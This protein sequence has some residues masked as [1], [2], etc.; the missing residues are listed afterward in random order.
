M[1]GLWA[2]ILLALLVWGYIYYRNN[3][4][5]T[6]GEIAVPSSDPQDTYEPLILGNKDKGIWSIVANAAE[7]KKETL[8]VSPKTGE[9]SQT[10]HV[11]P[12]QPRMMGK[13]NAPITMYLFSSLTCS[14]CV[15]YHL[16]TLPELEKK[17]IDTGKVKLVYIDLPFDRRA[18]AGAMLTRCV[19]PETYWKFLN[20]LFENQDQW[21]F[22]ENAQDIIDKYSAL[23]GLDKAD[24]QSCLSNKILQQSL[25][26]NR[27]I[28]M[29]KYDIQ[30]TP[31][32]V[33]IK[34]NIIKKIV[35]ADLK[36]LEDAINALDS[37]E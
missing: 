15:V 9:K 17:Y 22:K 18:L 32:T 5:S 35:G 29:E 21:A 33:L 28:F 19:K 2:I 6:L 34:N 24:M 10:I 11:L 16:K 8:S 23:P 13:E 3:Q 4:Y 7:L 12:E 20:V 25:I 14:H 36:E 26:Q 37:H 31:T 27:D 1:K 30:G